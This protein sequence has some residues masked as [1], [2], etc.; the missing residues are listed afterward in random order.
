MPGRRSGRLA[1]HDPW[2]SGMYGRRCGLH[3]AVTVPQPTRCKGGD[4]NHGKG[5]LAAALL[6]L[7]ASAIADD[8]TVTV[9]STR[10]TQRRWPV[11]RAASRYGS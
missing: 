10:P 9:G 7:C 5:F 11:S 8:S 4:M 6:G 1:L 3:T 2:T